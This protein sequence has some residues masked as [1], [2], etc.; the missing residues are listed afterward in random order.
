M[1]SKLNFVFLIFASSLWAIPALGSILSYKATIQPDLASKSI[2]GTT[3]ITVIRENEVV[4]P[5]YNLS[6][7]GVSIDGKRAPF[8]IKDQ[9]LII[10]LGNERDK[11]Q[12][13]DV[14]YLGQPQR[15]LVFG[16]NYVYSAFDT[17][18]WMICREDP[19]EKAHVSFEIIV[20]KRFSVVA[21]GDFLER[22]EVANGFVAHLWREN[23]SY[24]TYTFGFAAGEFHQAS[25]KVGNTELRYLGVSDH[26]ALLLKKFKDTER[27]LE[28]L[29]GKS[30]VPLPH[31]IYT[32]VLV[33]GNAAQE[34]SSFSVLGN[35]VIDPIL[36][37]PQ[38][39]WGIV[40][41]LAHQWWGNLLTCKSW[42]HFWLN[43]GITVF[44]VAAYKQQR[45]GQDAYDREMALAKRRYQKAIDAGL[46]VPLTYKGEFPSMGLKRAIVYSKGALFMDALRNELGEKHF[47]EGIKKYTQKYVDASVVSQDFQRLM[48]N[49]SGRKLDAIFK[50]WVY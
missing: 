41:E 10:S 2:R 4:F 46:D 3:S 11:K 40:H 35:E 20:P 38:E 48:E 42:D 24:S 14:S 45:W 49:T 5:V 25:M 19:G 33:P 17:C 12:I 18:A 26:S 7:T 44:M 15:G 22:R 23:R 16:P 8:Q 36:T 34:M 32:Q 28:F 43:E 30:G 50:K 27:M 29:I 21:S 31:K 6:V 13:I 47:W 37:D 1:G 9:Q 39:D